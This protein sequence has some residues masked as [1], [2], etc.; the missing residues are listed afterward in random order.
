MMKLVLLLSMVLTLASCEPTVDNCSDL[1]EQE[2]T[3]NESCKSDPAPLPDP[4]GGIPNEAL[5]LMLPSCLLILKESRKKKCI[6]PWILL[7]R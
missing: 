7:K 3:Q 2:K 4:V 5:S 6:R 1:Q